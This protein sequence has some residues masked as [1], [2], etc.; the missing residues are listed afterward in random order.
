M[1]DRPTESQTHEPSAPENSTFFEM[2]RPRSHMAKKGKPY[3][4]LN[5]GNPDT[6]NP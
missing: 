1:N 6:K 2:V 5:T 3:K 4:R